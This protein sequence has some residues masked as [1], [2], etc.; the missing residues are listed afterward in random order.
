[1]IF[2]PFSIGDVTFKNRIVRSSIGGRMAYYDGTVNNA[3]K[4]FEL[5]FAKTGVS[6][7]VSATLNVN[8]IRWSP[9]EYPQISDDKFVPPLR[10]AIAAIQ[11]EDCRYIIQIGDGGSHVQTSLFSQPQDGYGPSPGFDLLYGY[12]TRRTEMTVA[13]IEQTV[14]EFGQAARRVR[15]TGADGIEITASKGYLIHQFLN[16][17]INRRRDR[18]GGSVER[19]FRLLREVVEEVRRRV[20]D[21]FLLGVRISA[22]DRN[23][24]PL[25]LRWPI[26][27]PP[28]TY[29]E[30][31]DIGVYARYARWLRDL[32]VDYLHVSNGYGFINPGETPGRFPIDEARQ[33]ANSTRHLSAKAAFRAAIFNVLPR[34]LL[35]RIM[36]IGWTTGEAANLDD[37]RRLRA[38]SGLPVIANG[39]FQ[40][41]SVVQDALASGA[42]DLVSMAR[43]L[44]A[45]PDLV[46][47]FRRGREA[48]DRPC[49]L[50]N[51]CAMR[52]T[53]FPLG[54]YEPLRFDSS[55]DME[56]QILDWSARPDV[57][58]ALPWEPAGTAP[59]PRTGQG[60][61][62]FA[63]A[64]S[65]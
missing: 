5:R 17:A 23:R 36:N 11:A 20:G 9:L 40:R 45:N 33:F 3:W 42:C 51:R 35:D 41:R 50:C 29:L 24:L 26:T 18:Y 22:R 61:K 32:G 65:R 49:T 19:R 34:P 2:E 52:T 14:H 62:A 56:A 59:P 47:L 43:P 30:G 21:D 13:D 53:L 1:M 27:W 12:R 39:G 55:A 58:E 6:A 7:I 46:E 44:L 38:E 64:P 4:N 31:N 15:E 54:C 60:E 48:P 37:A 16:P 63:R 10:E 57:P 8:P 28:R 25:N